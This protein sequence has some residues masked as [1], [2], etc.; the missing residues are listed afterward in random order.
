MSVTTSTIRVLIVDDHILVRTG[1]SR[2]ME[3]APEIQIV[4]EADTVASAITAAQKLN[5]DVILMDLRLP[6]G[7]GVQAC[8]DILT[9]NPTANII[10][11]T[12]FYEDE[13]IL[14]AVLAGAKGYLSKHINPAALIDAI[15]Q[16][17]Q[18]RSILDPVVTGKAIQWM[19]DI[20]QGGT[21]GLSQRLSPQEERILAY[22]ADSKTN[23][24]IAQ[25]MNLSEKTVK[26]YLSN[27]FEKM[28]ITRRTQ[29]VAFYY[30]QRRP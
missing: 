16:T 25:A 17:A 13:S 23:K 29:A 21:L 27:V 24:E 7:S 5:P 28:N 3:R 11:L 22:V 2:V 9:T 12:S 1:I 10:F 6:D 30:K 8:Q 4:G 26:N 14:A 18:G 20:S 19:R 15:Q